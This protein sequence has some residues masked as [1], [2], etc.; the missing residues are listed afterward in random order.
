MEDRVCLT[1]SALREEGSFPQLCISL[2]DIK[3][4][5]KLNVCMCVLPA[6]NVCA[7][8]EGLGL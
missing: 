7:A 3:T 1:F 6:D 5:Q 4:S 8:G 2:L